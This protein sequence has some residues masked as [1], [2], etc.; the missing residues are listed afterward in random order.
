M[1]TSVNFNKGKRK[2]TDSQ[3][4]FVLSSTLP[5]KTLAKGLKVSVSYISHI[6]TG[7]RRQGEPWVNRKCAKTDHRKKLTE[8]QVKEISVSPQPLREIAEKYSISIASVCRIKSGSQRFSKEDNLEQT[9]MFYD[10]IKELDA[11]DRRMDLE[12]KT[13]TEIEHEGTN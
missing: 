3:I 4:Q 2:L 5:L 9:K 1:S 11:D 7:K 12:D 6:R 10:A 8:D 13:E